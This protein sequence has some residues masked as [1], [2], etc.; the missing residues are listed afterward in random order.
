M[1]SH[2]RSWT[3][4]FSKLGLEKKTRVHSTKRQRRKLLFE[5]C[6]ERCML[7]TFMVNAPYDINMFNDTDSIVTLREAVERANFDDDPDIIK[8]DASLLNGA[9][10]KL[11]IDANGNNLN[12]SSTQGELAITEAVTIDATMLTDGITIDASGN[13]DT[14]GVDNGDGSRVFNIDID[15]FGNVNEEVMLKGLTL[16]GADSFSSGGAIRFDGNSLASVS[17]I[18]SIEDS[19]IVGNHV[20]NTGGG[21]I[22]VSSGILNVTRSTVQDNRTEAGDGGG[23]RL[24]STITSA[25]ITDSK[26]VNNISTTSNGGGLWVEL[27]QFGIL[28]QVVT[29]ERSEFIG[30]KAF[31]TSFGLGNGGGIFADLRGAAGFDPTLNIIDTTVADNEALSEGG[32]VWVCTKHGATFNLKNSTISGNTVGQEA[33]YYEGP[34]GQGGGLWLAVAPFT[35]GE[36]VSTLENVTLS[37]NTALSQGGG[38]WI[39]VADLF[40]QGGGDLTAQL[41]HVTITKNKS[42]DGGGLYSDPDGTQQRVSTTLYNTIVS[43]NTVSATDSTPNNIAGKIVE[44]ASSYNFVGPGTAVDPTGP[45]NIIDPANDPHLAPLVFNGGL[46]K[47][48]MPTIHAG[49]PTKDAIDAGD[50]NFDDFPFDQR[51]NPYSRIFDGD[52]TLRTDIGAVEYGVGTPRVTDVV[53][54]GSD[55]AWIRE[56]FRFSSIVPAGAQLRPIHAKGI[57]TI[58]IQF[59]EDV[60]ITPT[61]NELTLS[62]T[63]YIPGSGATNIT[64]DETKFSFEYKPEILTGI[65]TFDQ[66]T[67][68]PL[69]NGKYAIHL[70]TAVTGSGGQALDGDW[71]NDDNGDLNGSGFFDDDNT[72]DDYSDDIGQTFL[73]G[74]GLAGSESDKFRFHFAILHG[75]YDQNGIVEAAD[76]VPGVVQD[77][78]GDGTIEDGPTGADRQIAIDNAGQA[79][80][81]RAAGGADFNDDEIV[82]GF[83]LGIWKDNYGTTGTPGTLDQQGD[84]DSDGDV[85]GNDFLL[86]S[87]RFNDYSAWY[88]GTINVGVG[89][90]MPL[91]LAEFAPRIMNLTISG[92]NSLHDP[93]AFDTV[94]GSG[95]QIQTVPVGGADTIS[96][97]FDELVN[98]SADSLRLIGLTTANVP[99]LAEFSYDPMTM[100]ATWRFEAWATGDLYLISL[101]D[102]V[103]DIDGNPLD[104]EWVNPESLSSDNSSGLISTFPSGDG[105]AG[106]NFNFVATL[107]PGDANLDGVVDSSDLSILSGNFNILFAQT[108][109]DGDFNGDGAVDLLD[110]GI[111][112][113]NW[114]LNLQDIWVLADLDGNFEVDDDDIQVINDNFGMTGATRADGDLDGDGVVGIEDLDLAFA[115]F[116]LGLQ[117]AS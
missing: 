115:Q 96:I 7:T 61:G 44:A 75:D 8:F 89:Y 39:G 108:F 78:N 36:L 28:P 87:S 41:D 81:L 21:A 43:G 48:H 91:I 18:L 72:P 111:V 110:L 50:P 54:E 103:T 11:G 66:P 24:A 105:W 93:Y 26:F 112:S 98:I 4:L 95:E 51:G 73:S 109:E 65:W 13:D 46:T 62:Q 71:N 16:T 114:L 84:V 101:P 40:D 83:D 14:L 106:G 64:L 85:D 5:Q 99:Q 32:G 42:P 97:T 20:L 3:V 52:G 58:K 34:T 60:S 1:R 88:E 94:V 102:S 63:K 86:W 33:T 67:S 31:G 113:P 57:D 116:G 9:I 80:P 25:T 17:A 29:I 45:G 92:S 56:P 30:N 100:T 6:E 90:T 79:L 104:G 37:G 69:S 74:D 55:S 35:T 68:T 10:I 27:R 12:F 38:A 117:V 76:A 19:S 23:V 49:D 77:G 59:S 53:L 47:T 82:N 107:L 22:E 2:S 70:S 15:A